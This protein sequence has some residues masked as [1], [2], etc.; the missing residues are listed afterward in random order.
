[1]GRRKRTETLVVGAPLGAPGPL[2]RPTPASTP[3]LLLR[4]GLVDAA[5][6]ADGLFNGCVLPPGPSAYLWRLSWLSLAS[7][8]VAVL[9]GHLDL[10]PVPL[11]VWLT[12]LLY[13]WRP[14]Y[15][16]RRYLDIAC[17]QFAL[18]YQVFRATHAQH[19]VPYYVLTFAGVP[20]FLLGTYL[21]A[22]PWSSALCHGMIHI[23][24]NA[25]NVW[26]YSGTVAPH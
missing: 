1:M 20:F 3:A 10:V 24:A 14:N 15:S 2:K 18:W 21:S 22:S 9:R 12:S 23:L 17:V 8:V 4:L 7:A 25:A 26:L 5:P 6:D 19:R 13:W 16:W 11:G